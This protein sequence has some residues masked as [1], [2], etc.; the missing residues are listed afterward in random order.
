VSLRSR[1]PRKAET[2]TKTRIPELIKQHQAAI[3]DTWL[4]NQL[5][6]RG[7]RSGR[8]T[9]AEG[10]EQ[11]RTLLEQIMESS[12]RAATDDL[13]DPAWM[14]VREILTEISQS[15][16]R[17]GFTPA[18]IARFV[19]SLKESLFG[20]MQREFASDPKALADETWAVNL[21]LDNLGLQTVEAAL[22]T[23]DEMVS[24]QQ[25]ERRN[26]FSVH[27]RASSRPRRAAHSGNRR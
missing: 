8:I 10:R 17:A 22:K 2:R 19:F 21:L 7:T 23:R 13:G 25:Q 3:L 4:R 26:G 27:W 18:E 16:A 15:R 12:Q 24:R 20:V 9:E 11:S 1:F 6:D 14:P 5:D